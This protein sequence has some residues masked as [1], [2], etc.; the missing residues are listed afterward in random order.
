MR[1]SIKKGNFQITFA[2]YL[3]ENSR[4]GG[5][6]KSPIHTASNLGEMTLTANVTMGDRNSGALPNAVIFPRFWSTGL[7]VDYAYLP[8]YLEFPYMVG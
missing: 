1:Q 8:Y 4:D 5:F 6:L 2:R 7:K 3:L